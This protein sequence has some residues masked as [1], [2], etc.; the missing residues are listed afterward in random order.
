MD[1]LFLNHCLGK[2]LHLPNYQ[3]AATV[4]GLIQLYIETKY[5]LLKLLL[6]LVDI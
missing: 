2:T 5:E 4:K 1:G 6:L 3:H